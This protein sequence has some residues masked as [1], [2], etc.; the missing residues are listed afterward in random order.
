M[1]HEVLT[2]HEDEVQ[3]TGAQLRACGGGVGLVHEV[4][5]GPDALGRGGHGRAQRGR[6]G[7]DHSDP[8][9]PW[10]AVDERR[11]DNGA[12]HDGDDQHRP[13]PE[14]PAAHTLTDL[15]GRH[16]AGVAQ[17]RCA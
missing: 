8:F 16:E 17:P 3:P 10:R 6:E 13:D 5:G 11:N 1:H 2:V 15:A 9:G 12:R 7:T 14:E 4:H